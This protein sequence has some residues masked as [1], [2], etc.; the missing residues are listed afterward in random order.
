VSVQEAGYNDVVSGS[1]MR[2]EGIKGICRLVRI[3]NSVA[4]KVT[5][6]FGLVDALCSVLEA[7]LQ[8]FRNF[9]SQADKDRERIAQREAMALIQRIVRS[10]DEAVE[11]L[12]YNV[13]LRKIL[14]QLAAQGETFTSPTSLENQLT[15]NSGLA[16][17][18]NKVFSVTEKKMFEKGP[19]K[20]KKETEKKAEKRVKKSYANTTISEYQNQV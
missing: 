16:I 11:V 12:R 4:L 10:S 13:R 19:E 6:D 2:L 18:T 1:S 9:R 17:A 3:D 5:Q 7:P 20:Q 14:S 8:G 15:S